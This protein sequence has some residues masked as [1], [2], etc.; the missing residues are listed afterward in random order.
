MKKVPRRPWSFKIR[1]AS[2]WLDRPASNVKLT[3]ESGAAE[4]VGLGLSFPDAEGAW[5]PPI[6]DV[7]PVNKSSTDT[8][9]AAHRPA[10]FLEVRIGPDTIAFPRE[11]IANPRCRGS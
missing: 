8:H 6:S 3:D 4:G 7:A 10:R 11:L 9:E 2:I 1:A 5:L